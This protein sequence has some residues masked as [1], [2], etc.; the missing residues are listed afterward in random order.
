MQRRLFRSIF[1]CYYPYLSFVS[2]LHLIFWHTRASG[3]LFIGLGS[4]VFN[5]HFKPIVSSL[6]GILGIATVGIFTIFTFF[7]HFQW[8][9]FDTI[10]SHSEYDL[11]RYFVLGLGCLLILLQILHLVSSRGQRLQRF[12]ESKYNAE[13]NIN[14]AIVFKLSR[15]LQNAQNLHNSWKNAKEM[16]GS[17]TCFGSA[18]LQFFK[19]SQNSEKFSLSNVFNGIFFREEGIWLSSRLLSGVVLQLVAVFF[20]SL[21]SS[22]SYHE[23]ISSFVVAPPYN[24]SLHDESY[25]ISKFCS[26]ENVES[27]YASCA[28]SL[29]TI[30]MDTFYGTNTCRLD[31]KKNCDPCSTVPP[32]L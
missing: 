20:F 9:T 30:L 2:F 10:P 7:Y 12:T 15:L 31:C 21:F 23:D 8:W 27:C 16:G 6:F 5:E 25:Y 22:Y 14:Q 3:L 1:F 18:L 4:V 32:W 26:F 13:K 24:C 29:S 11:A 17:L 28:Q 19:Q